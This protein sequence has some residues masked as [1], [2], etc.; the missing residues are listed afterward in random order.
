MVRITVHMGTDF[1]FTV[2][3]HLVMRAILT[4]FT[5][6]TL[7]TMA[8]LVTSILAVKKVRIARMTMCSKTVK[9]KSVRMCTVMRTTACI[10]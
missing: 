5:A 9:Q 4:F 7:V 3:E 6:R 8:D 2:I 10:T 1:C